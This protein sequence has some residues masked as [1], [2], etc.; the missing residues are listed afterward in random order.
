MAKVTGEIKRLLAAK[1]A[2]LD[3]G[4]ETLRGLLAEIRRQI[5]DELRQV[6]GDSYTALHLK[7]NLASIERYLAGFASA[8]AAEMNRLLDAAWESGGDLVPEA[9]RAGGFTL[10]FGHIPGPVLSTMK[11]YAFHKISGVSGAAFDKIR[12]E[13]TLGILGQKTPDQVITAIAGSVGSPGVFDSIE[14]RAMVIAR[15]EMGRAYSTATQEGMKQAARYVP[16]LKKQWWHAGHP[17]R[18]RRNHLA[19]HG[20]V[21]PVDEPFVIG[22]LSIDYPRAW[23]A[24]A[25]EV[26]RCGC[27]HVPW[28]EQ[29][30]QEFYALPIYDEQGLEIARR[31]ERSGSDE[32]LTGKFIKGQKGK[33]PESV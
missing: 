23:T 6:S 27:D 8:G 19:L 26:I 1:D 11:E 10:A 12:G 28:H 5:V 17:A 4:A 32:D 24:P 13:L 16:E 22:S 2:Q 7:S 15:T 20:Q 18:P 21:R 9:L 14:E 30:G 29:W 31:G 3:A 33:Q 25:S